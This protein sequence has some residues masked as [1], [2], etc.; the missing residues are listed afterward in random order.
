MSSELNFHSVAVTNDG[1][2]KMEASRG[3]LQAHS[4]KK[5][6]IKRHLGGKIAGLDSWLCMHLARGGSQDWLLVWMMNQ[7]WQGFVEGRLSSWKVVSPTRGMLKKL[8]DIWITMF[9]LGSCLLVLTPWN[10]RLSLRVGRTGVPSFQLME[11]GN[12]NKTPLHNYFV[13]YRLF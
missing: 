1:K 3:Q 10:K 2:G 5:R 4:K 11:Y 13:I 6:G 9:V 7:L 12:G 8:A